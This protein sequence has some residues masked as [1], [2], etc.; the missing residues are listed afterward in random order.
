LGVYIA[1]EFMRIQQGKL[2]VN[3]NET[4]LEFVFEFEKS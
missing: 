1:R 3:F 4:Y 2:S